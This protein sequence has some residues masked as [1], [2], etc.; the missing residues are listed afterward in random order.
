MGGLTAG[1]CGTNADEQALTSNSMA[2]MHRN[3]IADDETVEDMLLP[4]LTPLDLAMD[5]VE[6]D[7][8]KKLIESV[9]C[10]VCY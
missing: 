5:M 6:N 8:Q 10:C 1:C 9:L 4:M 3:L 7:L 2:P